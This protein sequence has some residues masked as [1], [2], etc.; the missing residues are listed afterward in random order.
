MYTKRGKLELVYE[1]S[2]WAMKRKFMKTVLGQTSSAYILQFSPAGW[3]LA[4]V[5]LA[6]PM[7]PAESPK[8]KWKLGTRSGYWI[9]KTKLEFTWLS[10][11]R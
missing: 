11:N 9:G 2:H 8:W 3:G 5:G 6:T 7:V 1:G 4:S 10:H